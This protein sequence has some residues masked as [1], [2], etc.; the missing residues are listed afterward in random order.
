MIQELYDR[1]IEGLDYQHF[2]ILYWTAVAEDKKA[3]YNITNVFDDL[4]S[5]DVTRTKQSAV[6]YVEA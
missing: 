6:S 3:R 2:L 1:Q 5:A 4:K